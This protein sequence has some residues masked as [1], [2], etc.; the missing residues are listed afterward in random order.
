MIDNRTPNLDL[1]LPNP[2]NLLLD[3]VTRISDSITAIDVAVANN[4]NAIATTNHDVAVETRNRT[5]EINN[6][7]ST[8][9][10]RHQNLTKDLN[11]IRILALA[12]L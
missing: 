12:G 4:A 5:T 6:L 10:Q 3:D 7:N 8:Y 9:D 2:Q 1:P 11:A